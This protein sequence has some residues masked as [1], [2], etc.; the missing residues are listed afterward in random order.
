MNPEIKNI[1]KEDNNKLFFT[2][3]NINYAFANAIRRIIL[4]EIPSLAIDTVEVSKNTGTL[5][6]NT[7]CHRLGLIPLKYKENISNFNYEDECPC[8]NNNC[9]NCVI[10]LELNISYNENKKLNVYSS[11][12][13]DIGKSRVEVVHYVNDKERELADKYLGHRKGIL[14]TKLVQD[15]TIN[16]ICSIRKGFGIKHAKWSCV[17]KAVYKT[18]DGKEF[19]FSIVNIGS[20]NLDDIIKNTFKIFFKKLEMIKIDIQ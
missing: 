4:S 20:V 9:E 14:I 8:Y 18:D 12:F 7:L 16:L 6:S 17:S 1:I 19:H 15:Q 5:D 13:K 3:S 2:I 11:D 10:K